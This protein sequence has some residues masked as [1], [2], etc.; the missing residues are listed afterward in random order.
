MNFYHYLPYGAALTKRC[1]AS[2]SQPARGRQPVAKQTQASQARYSIGE[3]TYKMQEGHC[4]IDMTRDDCKD[5]CADEETQAK[6][7]ES[8]KGS[9]TSEILEDV[10]NKESTPPPEVCFSIASR[11]GY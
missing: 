3:V 1:S 6:N 5:I 2:P 11:L 4:S 10:A 8:R 9:L 7:K